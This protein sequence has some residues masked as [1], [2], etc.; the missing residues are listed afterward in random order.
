MTC[1]PA[2]QQLHAQAAKPRHEA[3]MMVKGMLAR[4]EL[5]VA[6]C[7]ELP[8]TMWNLQFWWMH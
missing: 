6:A 1:L 3:T 8:L 2:S 7:V 4:W 5:Y